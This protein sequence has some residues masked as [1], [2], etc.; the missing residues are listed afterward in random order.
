MQKSSDSLPISSRSGRIFRNVAI[1]LILS[2]ATS[3]CDTPAQGG[4]P[5]E[6][7]GRAISQD[8]EGAMLHGRVVRIADGDTITVLTDDR[9]EVRIRL[10]EVD[11]PERGQPWGNRS[12]Q[13]LSGLVFGRDVR[14]RQTDVDRW[15]RVVGQ[16]SVGG[17]DVNREMVA[18]GAAWA[19]R[20]YL[21]DPSLIELEARAR[22][23][24]LGLWSMPDTETVPPWDWRQGARV[25]SPA[26]EQAPQTVQ[27]DRSL[28]GGFSCGTKTRCSQMASCAEAEHYFLQCGLT[29]IDGN[30]DGQ[31][32]EQLC[33]TASRQ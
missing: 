3:S 12:R 13:V 32:C 28:T 27:L 10:A 9:E 21:T 14:V 1:A 20:Q 31:P 33:G 26:S 30:R 29:T 24:R 19:Y 7:S 5:S 2:V 15:G 18:R 8:A 17:R 6:Q 22:H 16:V 4:T 23:D 11:A 25:A